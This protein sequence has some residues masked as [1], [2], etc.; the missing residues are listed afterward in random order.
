VND[1]EVVLVSYRSRH[2][3]EEL[4]QIWPD[5]LPVAVVDNSADSDGISTLVAQRPSLRYLDGGG[6]GFARAA[7]LGAF[8]SAHDYVVFV[9]PDSRPTV[10]QLEALVAGLAADPGAAAHAGTLTGSDGAL[11]IGTG[12]WEPSVLRTAVHATGLHKRF[13]HSGLFAKPEPGEQVSVDWACGACLAVRTDQFRSLGGFDETFFVY[14]EDIS[15]GRRVR[16]AGLRS[17]L[18]SDIVVPHGAG[19]SGAPSSEMLR[20]RGAS[21]AHYVLRYHP[22]VSGALMRLLFT[23]GGVVRAVIQRVRG[24]VPEARLNLALAAGVV[25][26]RAYVGRREVARSRFEETGVRDSNRGLAAG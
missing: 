4:L 11:E 12:G 10:A 26:R 8:S 7:N 1:F 19:S 6:Q 22:S 14:A 16:A 9:N 2:H 25:T 13:P 15:F 21:F 20:I 18:R 24:N 17:V 5:D 3:V 23:M